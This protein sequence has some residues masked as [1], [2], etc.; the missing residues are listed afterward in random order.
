MQSIT[1]CIESR[2]TGPCTHY[3]KGFCRYGSKCMYT[4]IPLLTL[5]QKA[6]IQCVFELGGI[7]RYGDKCEFKHDQQ[8]QQSNEVLNAHQ[9]EEVVEASPEEVVEASPEEVVEA[10]HE[11]VVEASPEEVVEAGLKEVVEAS[12]EEVVEAG[13]KEVVEYDS[14]ECIL[15]FK[16]IID[17]HFDGVISPIKLALDSSEHDKYSFTIPNTRIGNSVDIRTL[18]EYDECRKYMQQQMTLLDSRAFL[19]IPIQRDT[20][21]NIVRLTVIWNNN[22]MSVKRTRAFQ[23]HFTAHFNTTIHDIKEKLNTHGQFKHDIWIPNIHMMDSNFRHHI[24]DES[25]RKSLVSIVRNFDERAF[26]TFP[27]PHGISWESTWVKMIIVRQR[28]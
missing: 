6:Q 2:N 27:K 18:V 20:N 4:H 16:G 15:L 3:R 28:N 7:C 5:E 10:G 12:P 23:A 11:E 9:S 19:T 25:F 22:H 8:K 17:H 14:E 1:N 26:L 24:G 21:L 13:L